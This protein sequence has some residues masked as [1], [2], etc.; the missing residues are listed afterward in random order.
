MVYIE[1]ENT[2]TEPKKRKVLSP[3]YH[4]TIPR[5]KIREVARKIKEMRKAVFK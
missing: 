3:K 4:G 1:I 5:K 2:D